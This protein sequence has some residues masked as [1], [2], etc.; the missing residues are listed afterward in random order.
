MAIIALV[1]LAFASGC[2]DSKVE[3]TEVKRIDE[4]V[5]EPELLMLLQIVA[6]LPN[7]TVPP[8]P[9]LFA[10]PPHW[11]ADRTL[12]VDE[13]VVEEQR[14]MEDRHSIEALAGRCTATDHCSAC[15]DVSE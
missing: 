14:L 8:M 13:L 15:C 9:P 2:A 6:Q 5:T 12:P 3:L 10:P 7:K 1:A 4:K 11:S